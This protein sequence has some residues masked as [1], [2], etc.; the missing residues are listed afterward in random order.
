MATIVNKSGVTGFFLT[1]DRTEI[2]SVNVQKYK[3]KNK[4]KNERGP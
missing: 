3:E 4:N 1:V 2:R